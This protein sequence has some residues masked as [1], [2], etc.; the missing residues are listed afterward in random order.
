M[1]YLVDALGADRGQ[2]G[3]DF[4]HPDGHG[5]PLE[6]VDELAGLPAPVV[7]RVMGANLMELLALETAG[8]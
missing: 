3:S 5:D 7:E 2:F 8:R 6:F 4:P 1:G